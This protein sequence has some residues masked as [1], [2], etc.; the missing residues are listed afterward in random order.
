VAVPRHVRL[1][2]L[3][4]GGRRGADGGGPL[5]RAVVTGAG[6]FVGAVLA[7]R[8]LADGHE[9]DLWSRPGADAWR[10]ASL[11]DDAALVELDLTDA[12]AVA[13]RIRAAAP[14]VVFHLAAHGAYSWQRDTA[15]V[16]RVNVLGTAALLEACA[17]AGVE[18]VVQAGSSS[19]YGDKDHPPAEDEPVE[20]DSAYAVGK[21]AATTLARWIARR[22]G[23]V[24]RTLR[25]YS[26]YG[27]WEEPRRLVPR[28]VALGVRG[29]LPPLADPGTP[30]DYVYVDD[31][32]EAFLA[33]A[34]AGAADADPAGVYNIG[35]GVQTTLAEMVDAV[36]DVLGVD[37]EP[38]WG[39]IG[40]RDWDTDVWVSDP[41]RARREL[42][43]AARTPMRDGLAATARWL[44]AAPEDVRARYDA[45]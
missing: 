44:G 29:Q 3:P 40:N 10:I 23:S 42:G 37:A 41:S 8:L 2:E 31:A 4:R 25:L 6:G 45:G 26:V 11:R 7:R 18:K 17:A 9:I 28:L 16:L 22:D 27:P 1:R 32:C 5:S 13:T 19:E 38:R 30:R 36:R 20:P 35:S 33:A 14:D 12:D 24:V 39:S 34:R 43:W 21:A 15:E